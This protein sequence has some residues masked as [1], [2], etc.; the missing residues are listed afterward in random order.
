MGSC[1]ICSRPFGKRKRC[2]VCSPGKRR[3]GETRACKVCGEPFYV[4]RN[5][6]TDVARNSGTY[7][8]RKCKG[9]AEALKPKPWARPDEKLLH[10]AGYVL[11]WRPDHPRAVHRGRVFEHILVAEEKIGRPLTTDDHVH[12]V[13]GDKQNNHPDNLMVL[14]NSEHQKLHVG[15]MNKARAKKRL[16]MRERLAEYERRFGPLE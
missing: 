2:Y 12:H 10:P 13:D 1:P 9:K 16:T 15:R 11:V 4:Q 8:S 3:T 6:A 5:Q 7:C 14:S